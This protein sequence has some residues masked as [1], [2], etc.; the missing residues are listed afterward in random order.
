M[1]NRKALKL[2]AKK[3]NQSA[4]VNAY[5]FSLLFFVISLAIRAVQSYVDRDTVLLD[6]KKFGTL[7][8]DAVPS[9]D[10]SGLVDRVSDVLGGI[11]AAIPAPQMPSAAVT[12]VLV[13]AWLLSSL[14]NA[15]Y[16][17]YIMGIRQGKTMGYG[18]LFDG[19]AFAGKIILLDLWRTFVVTVWSF[20]FV[21]PGIIAS[22]RYSFALYNLLNDP[23]MGVMEAM[24]LSKK[25]TRGYKA[26]LFVMDL[27]FIGWDILTSLTAGI[28]LIYVKPFREQTWMGYYR[29]ITGTGS[30]EGGD[31]PQQ[32][33][34]HYPCIDDDK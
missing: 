3:L 19:F 1:L 32:E 30:A 26:D 21:I 22:Y 12:F 33:D 27:S 5:N 14:L 8:L 9:A 2:E 34:Y 28:L 16:L 6:L 20:V 25:Q 11:S 23:E 31:V 7:L 13:T 29:A 15:G 4:K 17:L 10:L 24:A 18:T